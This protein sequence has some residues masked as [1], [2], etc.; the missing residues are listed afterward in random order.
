MSKK[1]LTIDDTKT[2]RMALAATLSDAGHEVVE[3]VDGQHGLEVYGA[4][5]PDLVITDLNMPVMDGI[6]FVRQCRARPDG[7]K[8]PIIILTTET[9]PEMKSEGRRAGATGWMV[10]PFNPD[11]LLSIIDRVCP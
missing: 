2:L 6:E 1:V 5:A 4:E 8:V 9:S 10:K 7:G 11:K 3:A